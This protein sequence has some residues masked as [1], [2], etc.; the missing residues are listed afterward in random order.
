MHASGQPSLYI[1]ISQLHCG[2][3]LTMTYMRHPYT[4]CSGHIRWSHRMPC[5][6]C[7]VWTGPLEIA[8]A[9]C[10]WPAYVVQFLIRAIESDWAARFEICDQPKG[11]GLHEEH[12]SLGS[13]CPTVFGVKLYLSNHSAR[14]KWFSVSAVFKTSRKVTAT[15]HP[16]DLIARTSI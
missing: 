8:V 13:S 15:P 7:S 5:A 9:N 6:G 12:Q 4:G 1:Q 11:S 10:G 2:T 16:R 14:P 3:D